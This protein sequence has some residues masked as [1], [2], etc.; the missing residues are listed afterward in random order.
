MRHILKSSSLIEEPNDLP[1][2][3]LP[4][5]L[6]M[7]H[8]ARGRRQHDIP[9]LT[10]GK[11]L[12]DPFFKVV[13]AHVVPGRDDAGLVQPKIT[14]NVSISVKSPLQ[15]CPLDDSCSLLTVR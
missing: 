3:M 4:P 1:G 12:D 7:V 5:R 11:Q 2:N 15:K 14:P 10:R 6:L 9:K 8:D 13:D